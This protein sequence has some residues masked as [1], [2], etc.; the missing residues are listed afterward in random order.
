MESP[1][2]S[3]DLTCK[4]SRRHLQ[5]VVQESN[6]ERLRLEQEVEQ[7]RAMTWPC[8][9]CSEHMREVSKLSMA[10]LEDWLQQG[11]LVSLPASNH[12]LQAINDS[13]PPGEPDLRTDSCDS[14]ASELRNQVFPSVSG[15][16]IRLRAALNQALAS[17]SLHLAMYHQQLENPGCAWRLRR[18]PEA[19]SAST[20]A[21]EHCLQPP[22]L[23][24]EDRADSLGADAMN[25]SLEP[26]VRHGIRPSRFGAA[27]EATAVGPGDAR[28]ALERIAHPG[29]VSSPDSPQRLLNG[30]VG[31]PICL[32]APSDPCLLSAE[33]VLIAH[34]TFQAHHERNG[35][36]VVE[37]HKAVNYEMLKRMVSEMRARFS[38][39]HCCKP[40]ELKH[41]Q[42][43]AFWLN[44]MN[45]SILGSLCLL[46]VQPGHHGQS[47]PMQD[48]VT[49]FQQS[50]ISVGGHE[51]SLF[52]V[53]HLMLRACSQPP[54]GKLA[55]LS[56]QAV[57]E[58]RKALSRQCDMRFGCG[59]FAMA[60]ESAAPEVSF[61]ISYPIRS[62]C[63]PLRVY[64]PKVVVPQL[65]LNCAHY[66]HSSLQVN[67]PQRQVQLPAIFRYYSND[68]GASSTQV[69][70]FV[71][72]ILLA[73][74]SALQRVDKLIGC[75]ASRADW[76]LVAETRSLASKFADF[77]ALALEVS[78][79]GQASSPFS[80]VSLQTTDFDWTLDF[81][82][83]AVVCPAFEGMEYSFEACGVMDSQEM[84]EEAAA[85]RAEINTLE[86][87]AS[88]ME[89]PKTCEESGKGVQ[90]ALAS[91][92]RPTEYCHRR[93]V[94]DHISVSSKNND[95]NS[96]LK[97]A[98]TNHWQ[99][100]CSVEDTGAS[101]Q[102]ANS[103]VSSLWA[104]FFGC[105]PCEHGQTTSPKDMQ[106]ASR[107]RF[108]NVNDS[109]TPLWW[110]AEDT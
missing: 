33:L 58:S 42:R 108:R 16:Q 55:W 91:G 14:S 51:I 43:L 104:F 65:I 75:R 37:R 90:D 84:C 97:A 86:V 78:I 67:L 6:V 82:Q 24:I 95:L 76:N 74:P 9:D 83:S 1:D 2:G 61:G 59:L 64:R 47:S 40:Q 73:V 93:L 50:Y 29:F 22:D 68:F 72:S 20:S 62:G 11:G 49:F 89:R 34:S 8:S 103:H 99:D 36:N 96:S 31:M 110:T 30:T 26:V 10:A 12:S 5:A 35:T 32:P 81:S 109:V 69:L 54:T 101:K 79:E 25:I 70:E 41:E 45:A 66:I 100:G 94:S 88:R 46:D 18:S 38:A 87:A 52:E 102:A 48:W 57:H 71:R 7:F 105:Q 85:V 4:P 44:V 28:V 15:L 80:C 107:A 53:E 60:L 98:R 23:P 13:V 63:P 27:A 56:W 17:H 21:G 39:L 92:C 106:A 77:Q 19:T 3:P